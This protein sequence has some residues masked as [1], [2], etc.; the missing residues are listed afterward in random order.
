MQ[1]WAYYIHSRTSIIAL[2]F[3][4]EVARRGR[5]LEEPPPEEPKSDY[6]FEY[7]SFNM[8]RTKKHHHEESGSHDGSKMG[9]YWWDSADGFRHVVTY[10][11]NGHGF[12]PMHSKFKV[13]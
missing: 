11:A 12:M 7:T 3:F 13:L 10:V 5:S 6:F 2:D 9:S 8:E 1:C 4:P